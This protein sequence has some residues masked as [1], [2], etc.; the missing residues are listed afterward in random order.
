MRFRGIGLAAALVVAMTA[1]AATVMAAKKPAAPA[2]VD[3]KA[4]EKGM[5]EA[6]AFA[7]AAGLTCTIADARFI[8]ADAKSGQSFYEVACNPG[9][10]GVLQVK[11]DTPKPAF[12]TCLET[13]KPGPD[14]KPGSLAC[15]LPGNADVN[16]PLAAAVAAAGGSCTIE[17]ARA[18]G[19]SPSSSFFEIACQGGSG[20][21]VQTTAPIDVTTSDPAKTPKLLPCLQFEAGDNLACELTTRE[22]Q[23]A[24][25]DQL[26]ASSGKNC[27]VKDKRYVLSTK[28]GSKYFEVACQDGKGYMLEQAANGSLA[29]S[30]D[31]LNA[32][33]VG[34]GCTMTDTV[35]AK[36]EQ[37]NLYSSLA[38][39]AGF[40]CAVEKYGV[41][42]SDRPSKEVVELKCS[43]RP[44]GAIAVFDGASNSIYNC[45]ISEA[46]GYRCSFTPKSAGFTS[47]T[48]DLKALGKSDCV[49]S[50]ARSMDKRTA[51]A[52]YLEVAC[53]DGLPGWVIAYGANGKAKEA[54]SCLQGQQLGGCK[55]PTNVRK[56][57]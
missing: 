14:G 55:L 30:I 4:R 3:A 10:G 52:G 9:V 48:G 31:C 46:L 43:D 32:G 24:V 37:N 35:A 28:D 8:G 49:V 6:P 40:K 27:T 21:I 12:F 56:K 54:L 29:R 13:G 53:S 7:T 57:S 2:G 26:A 18:I 44:D 22:A 36:T 17:K 16:A 38:T 33:F 51:D 11:K 25:A 19:S 20:Y 15:Q 1:P 47:V 23:L 41:L 42:P 34:G 45:A 39:K 5:A 50:D